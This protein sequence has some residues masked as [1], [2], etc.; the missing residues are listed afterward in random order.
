MDSC[1][2]TGR[3]V[4]VAYLGGEVSCGKLQPG[5]EDGKGR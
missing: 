1:A 4:E 2:L 5:M 3:Q